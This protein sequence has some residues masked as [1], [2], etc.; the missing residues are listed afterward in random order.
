MVSIK[1]SEIKIHNFA[2]AILFVTCCGQGSEC[3]EHQEGAYM[4]TLARFPKFGLGQV[5]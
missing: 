4:Y 5:T 2:V 1:R 3:K